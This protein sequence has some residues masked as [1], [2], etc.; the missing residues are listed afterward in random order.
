MDILGVVLIKSI[1]PNMLLK[2]TFKKRLKNHTFSLSNQIQLESHYKQIA[3]Y[4]PDNKCDEAAKRICEEK[5]IINV[6]YNH[7]SLY[8]HVLS[9]KSTQFE[10]KIYVIQLLPKIQC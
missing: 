6:E 10:P 8:L 7:T 4:I 3:Y 5:K 2:R 1:T 9:D